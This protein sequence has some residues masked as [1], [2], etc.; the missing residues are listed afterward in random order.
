M[1]S[2]DSLVFCDL[3]PVNSS[4]LDMR[5][6]YFRAAPNLRSLLSAA[7]VFALLTEAATKTRRKTHFDFH[8]PFIWVNQLG[9]HTLFLALTTISTAHCPEAS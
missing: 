6:D 9:K 4:S 8:S 2:T 1:I 5:G 3:R 7:V